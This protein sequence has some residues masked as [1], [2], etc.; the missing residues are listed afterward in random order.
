MVILCSMDT[1][2]VKLYAG[3]FLVVFGFLANLVCHPSCTVFCLRGNPPQSCLV[4][5]E[6]CRPG[7]HGVAR[8]VPVPE[9]R[10]GRNSSDW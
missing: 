5:H 10:I 7:R 2:H 8:G 1:V 3:M 4:G 6:H 9:K